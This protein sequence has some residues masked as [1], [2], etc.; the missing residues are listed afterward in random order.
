LEIVALPD[1]PE[2]K[3]TAACPFDGVAARFDGPAALTV[4][5]TVVVTGLPADGVPVIV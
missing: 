3:E 4:I 2:V 5:A 1:S